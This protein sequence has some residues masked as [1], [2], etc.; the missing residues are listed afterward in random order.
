MTTLRA[1][2]VSDILDIRNK[3]VSDVQD[4]RNNVSDVQDIGYPVFP[5]SWISETNTVLLVSSRFLNRI[6]KY[7]SP[8]LRGL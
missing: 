2:T 4:I 7:F 1:T 3:L 8:M 6:S 5:I